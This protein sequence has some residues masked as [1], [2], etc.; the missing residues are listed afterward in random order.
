MLIT[1]VLRTTINF[2]TG[3]PVAIETIFAL[4]VG[5]AVFG[6]FT[7]GVIR[8]GIWVTRINERIGLW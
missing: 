7:F 8:T 2:V 5:C 3:K 1:R 6:V 4:T